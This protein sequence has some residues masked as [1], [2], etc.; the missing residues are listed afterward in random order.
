[1][2]TYFV[3]RRSRTPQN[4][5]DFLPAVTVRYCSWPAEK[6]GHVR[7][8]LDAPDVTHL[9]LCL[10]LHHGRYGGRDELYAELIAMGTAC[11]FAASFEAKSET[12]VEHYLRQRERFHQLPKELTHEIG[13][14]RTHTRTA[15][16][17]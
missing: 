7:V 15:D 8:T 17:G 16:R 3:V 12:E 4:S 5:S 10:D 11:D 14:D 13:T 6:V 1:M 9:L 2:H